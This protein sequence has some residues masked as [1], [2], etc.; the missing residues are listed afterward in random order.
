MSS[1]KEFTQVEHNLSEQIHCE[2]YG[3]FIV[4]SMVIGESIV[5]SFRATSWHTRSLNNFIKH[6]CL[7]CGSDFFNSKVNYSYCNIANISFSTLDHFTISKS[8]FD[9]I[10]VYR[11]LCGDVDNQSDHSSV[12]M[13]L[14]LNVKQYAINEQKLPHANVGK[15]SRLERD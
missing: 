2:I 1:F 14:A 10:K 4:R 13:S 6:E 3:E 5:N 12:K 11:S 7:T 15:Q 9:Y 8:L